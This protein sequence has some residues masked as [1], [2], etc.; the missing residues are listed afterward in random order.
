MSLVTQ[1]ILIDTGPLVA[2]FDRN[3][4]YHQSCV[5]QAKLLVEGL[6]TCWPVITEACYLLRRRRDLVKSLLESCY[7]GIYEIL[8]LENVEIPEISEVMQKYTDQ[9]IDFADASLVCLAHRE[10]I[11][12]VMTVDHRHFSLFRTI[13]GKPFTILPEPI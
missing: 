2:L 8:P 5:D 13:D 10:R 3:D 12:H 9:S 7:D 4:A 6:Y 1:P 11:D